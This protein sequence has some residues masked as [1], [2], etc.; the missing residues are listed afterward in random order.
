[1]KIDLKIGDSLICKKTCITNNN[2][3]T[4]TVGKSYPIIKFGSNCIIIFNDQFEEH[5]FSY[6]KI[7]ESYYEHWFY[8]EK[9]YRKQKL[10]KINNHENTSRQTL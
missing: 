2:K 10:L 4:T 7:D 6:E 1:M 3:V 8:S 9:E 5:Y